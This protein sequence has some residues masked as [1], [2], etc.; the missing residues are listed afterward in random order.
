MRLTD[1]TQQEENGTIGDHWG[2]SYLPE[3][4][5]NGRIEMI[6]SQL[7]NLMAWRRLAVSSR[8]VSIFISSD[9]TVRQTIIHFIIIASTTM[10]SNNLFLNKVDHVP[11]TSDLPCQDLKYMYLQCLTANTITSTLNCW[12]HNHGETFMM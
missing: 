4:W 12:S 6:Q 9:Y 11:T 1:N 7:V 2:N 5:N 3:Q 10:N 8:N